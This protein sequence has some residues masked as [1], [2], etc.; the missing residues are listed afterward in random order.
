MT[1]IRVL[2]ANVGVPIAEE[3]FYTAP[4]LPYLLFMDSRS[5]RG[6]DSVN[7]IVEREITL[8]FYATKITDEIEKKIEIAINQI[9]VEFTRDRVWIP[10]EKMYETIYSF[11]LIEKI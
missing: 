6:A 2:L 8:E 10:S 3:S 11:S 1:D 4:P 5:Y 9:P 7:K